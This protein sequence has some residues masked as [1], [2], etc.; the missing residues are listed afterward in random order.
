[1]LAIFGERIPSN[2][3][4]N[5]LVKASSAYE[6]ILRGAR[7][8][9]PVGSDARA[10]RTAALLAAGAWTE[11]ALALLASE[12]DTWRLTSLQRD[13]TDWVCTLSRFPRLPRELDEIIE[14]RDPLLPLATLDALAESHRRDTATIAS[15]SPEPPRRS[16]AVWTEDVFR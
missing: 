4:R 16:F 6:Q 3:S 5:N 2:R 15:A 1:M 11:A 8:Y 9:Q 13:G 10:R 12:Q 7:A 14:G